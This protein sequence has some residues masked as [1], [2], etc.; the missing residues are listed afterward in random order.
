WQSPHNG[1]TYPAGWNI[2][3]NT[4]DAQPLKISLKPLLADQEL[5]GS[6]NV[7][8]WEGAVQISGDQTGYGYAELT[9]YFQAMT[10]RF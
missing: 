7:D 4:G 9:G 8:Y 10:G 2:T 3:V 1:A 5:H 6:G